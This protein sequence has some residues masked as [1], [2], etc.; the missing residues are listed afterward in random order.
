MVDI[1]HHQDVS[2]TDYPVTFAAVARHRAS[3]DFAVVA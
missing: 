3:N 2:A 1:D